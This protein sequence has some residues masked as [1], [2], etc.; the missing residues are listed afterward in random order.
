M[1]VQGATAPNIWEK[2]AIVVLALWTIGC[3]SLPSE[4]FRA[5]ERHDGKANLLV[6][7][8]GFNSS[9][10]EAWG[11]FIPLIKTDKGFDEYDILSYGYP[12]Q[13]CGQENDIRD[14]GAHLKSTLMEEL[15]RYNTTI[16][17][18]HSMGGLVVLNSLL[19]LES[20]NFKL[21]SNKHLLVMSLGTPYYGAKMAGLF[22]GLC[23][24][25]QGE[26]MQVLTKEGARLMQDWQRRINTSETEADRRTAKIPVYPFYGLRDGLV[27]QASACGINPG[28]CDVVDGDHTLIAKPP[29]REHLTYQKLQAMID[30]A[31]TRGMPQSNLNAEPRTVDAMATLLKTCGP[32]TTTKRPAK[33]F[34]PYWAP[35][36]LSLRDRRNEEHRDLHNLMEVRGRQR[37]AETMTDTYAEMI[38]TLKC[39]QG[40]GD[41]KIKPFDPP[42]TLGEGH[43][44]LRIIF[45]E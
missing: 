3:S 5:W 35:H 25:P 43:E 42:R 39:L 19:E 21:A 24:N 6:F 23:R 28:I 32:S 41:L 36:I 31:G 22:G 38:F 34:V 37:I 9:K 2:T 15:P 11:S 26:A 13:L 30:K 12:Q 29:N 18:A 45:P 10:D 17:V 8:P 20:S 16:F 4:Q 1:S 33:D 7:V 40:R 27:T 44:N 14:V